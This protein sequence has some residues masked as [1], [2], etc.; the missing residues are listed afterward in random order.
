MRAS[1]ARIQR[2]LSKKVPIEV[3]KTLFGGFP[4]MLAHSCGSPAFYIRKRPEAGEILEADDCIYPNGD[5]VEEPVCFK[6]K[7]PLQHDDFHPDNI[8]VMQ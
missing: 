7:Q 6:C 1:N 3:K 5:R 4:Y 8:R 2:R